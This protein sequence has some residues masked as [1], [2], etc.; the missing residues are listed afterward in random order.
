MATTVNRAGFWNDQVWSSIDDGVTKAALAIRV[1]QKVFPVTQLPDVTCVPA[2]Q[3]N[4]E[5][6]SIAEGLTR[7]YVELAVEFSLTNGQVNADPAGATAITLSKLAAKAL[8]LGED[9][10]I[11]QGKRGY[12]AF[13]RPHRIR[14]R[15]ATRVTASW[16]WCRRARLW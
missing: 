12:A 10:V 4:P 14:R 1:A 8:A 6:M 2:D 15:I 16:G 7:P 11:L 3:F 5:K 9:M 13:I